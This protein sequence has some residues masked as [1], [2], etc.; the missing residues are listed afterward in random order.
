MTD[1]TATL[2]FSDGT[3]PVT[4]GDPT[5]EVNDCVEVFDTQ[6]GALG[7]VCVGD[8]PK[9]FK[10]SLYVGPYEECGEYTFDNTAIVRNGSTTLGSDSWTVNVDVPCSAGCTLGC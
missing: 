10:Y 8:S 1:R 3:A 7:E 2:T 4:F 9:Q 5:T 6:K